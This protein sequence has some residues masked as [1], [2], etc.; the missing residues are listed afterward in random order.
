MAVR[1]WVSKRCPHGTTGT[2]ARGKRPAVPACPCKQGSWGWRVDG[3]EDP[4]TG[5]RV[6]P[7]KSGYPTKAAATSALNET[8]A[9]I[10]RGL[11][12][13]DG[14]YTVETW[15]R[16][17][18]DTGDWE[19]TTLRSYRGHCELYLIPL[20]GGVRLR[21]LDRAAIAACLAKVAAYDP[22]RPAQKRTKRGG[23]FKAQRAG[24]TVDGVRRTLR[25]ALTYALDE[26]LVAV[27]HA[28][29]RFKVIPSRATS[30]SWWQPE[31]LRAFL[32]HVAADPLCALWTVAGLAGLRREELAG[33]RWEDV[34]L[35]STPP[36]I[37]IRQRTVGDLTGP[38][39]CSVCGG[40]HVGRQIRPG[41]KTDAGTERWVP[42]TWESVGQL[43][44]HQALQLAMKERLGD[45][46]VDHGLVFAKETGEPFRPDAISKRHAALVKDAGLPR[47]VLHEMRHGAVSL[48][49]AAG[50]TVDQV[51]M[52]VGHASGDVVRKIYAHQIRSELG[53]G[54]DRAADLVRA[55]G[56]GDVY[57]R[58]Q[59]V[60][61]C[62]AAGFV[63]ES[64]DVIRDAPAERFTFSVLGDSPRRVLEVT[65]LGRRRKGLDQEAAAGAAGDA[66]SRERA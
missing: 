27:N 2:P 23:A 66:G 30:A 57:T 25:S 22:D 49:L 31:Q 29:G 6:Q 65:L 10:Q 61:A 42:L 46:Y 32:D 20:L 62:E 54:A 26:G 16:H 3:G 53:R 48:L 5:K 21:E 41:A 19:P 14:G 12:V 35:T 18:L 45:L 33:V 64:D 50:L 59:Y 52:V 58:A 36:G 60:T 9:D 4:S 15:L 56:A 8:I 7:S 37:T 11:L 43:L 51:A 63:P 1:G 38:Q 40:E 28:A 55:P 39:P 13:S 17:W 44:A 47:I 34:D 24:G